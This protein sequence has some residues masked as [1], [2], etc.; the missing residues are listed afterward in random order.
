MVRVVDRRKMTEEKELVWPNEK[1]FKDGTFN[2][3]PLS[4]C[5]RPLGGS[6]H[7]PDS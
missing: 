1:C 4:S 6:D 5:F 7:R 3:L 2:M